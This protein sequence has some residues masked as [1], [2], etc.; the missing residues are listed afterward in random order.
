MKFW[1][2]IRKKKFTMRVAK[3]IQGPREAVENSP[4][5]VVKKQQDK[6]LNNLSGRIPA[7]WEAGLQT[8]RRPFPLK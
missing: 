1:L 4:L 5:E 7:E 6:A 3:L 2:K 8:S